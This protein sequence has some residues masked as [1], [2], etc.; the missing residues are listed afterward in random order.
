MDLF[1]ELGE[2]ALAS[3]LRRLSDRLMRDIAP[4]YDHLDVDFKPRWFPVFQV[5]GRRPALGVTET[6]QILGL[7]HPAVNQ[8]ITSMQRFALVERR[9]DPDDDRRILLSLTPK[10]RETYDTL[11]PVW[12]E[13]RCSSAEMLAEAGCDLLGDLD[14]IE[15][16]LDLRTTGD[17]VRNRL[18]LPADDA[19]E[20]VDYRP[21][22][23]KHFASLNREWL[24]EW[25]RV[26]DHDRRILDDP[27]QVVMH[28]GGTILFAL[29]RGEVVGT[30]ALLKRESGTFE[31][32]KMA[33]TKSHRGLGIGRRLG[34][35][36]LERA[37]TMGAERVV[38]A[39]SPVLE[40]A[41]RLYESL[42]FV[43]VPEGPAEQDGYERCSIS[44][45]L[46]LNG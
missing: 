9:R 24:E 25:F 35:A 33:V 12:E 43:K 37:R 17:R 23:K 39:T 5:L 19:L 41:C 34:T 20:I 27:N 36:V 13:I 7:T 14:K 46:E 21:A 4:I 3:R 31:L 18:G 6:A 1:D 45:Q 2:L 8:I 28:K 10:G 15:R 38:L 11:Q 40:R 32:S 42:G 16:T 30:C 29:H 26:E 44:M 22:Y